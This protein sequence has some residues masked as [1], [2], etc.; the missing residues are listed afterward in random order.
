MSQRA[1]LLGYPVKHSISPAIHNA[2]FRARGL[3]V[4]YETREVPPAQL[5]SVV[6]ELRSDDILGANVT[7][8][9]KEAVVPF[10]DEIDPT[11]AAIGAIN[12]IWNDGG[13]LRASNTDLE[14]FARSLDEAGID[15]EDRVVLV[16]GA[17]GSA[18]AVAEALARR[19]PARLIIANRHAERADRLV[20]ALQAR[21]PRLRLLALPLAALGPEH[22][23]GCT[24]V[25]N[26]TTVGLQ[27]D[28]TPLPPALLPDEGAVVDIIYN[29]PRTRLL[30]DAERAGLRTLN[31][32]PMLV[33]QAAAAWEQ[34]TGQTAPLEVM[35]AAA[36]AAL[37]LVGVAE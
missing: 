21:Y 12:T 17:G 1:L 31:G 26:T 6:A 3:P 32:L 27:D 33:H 29:P 22:V 36:R 11:A 20:A 25:V 35:F 28:A 24:L 19:S 5:A 15:V 9:H 8:P 34:W 4:T 18:R 16:L 37:G 14:G 7:V 13:R 23:C 30:R 2:A 10:V